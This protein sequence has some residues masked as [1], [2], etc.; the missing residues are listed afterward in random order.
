[1][2][3]VR[4]FASIDNYT[5]TNAS[6]QFDNAKQFAQ[7]CEDK[8]GQSIMPDQAQQILLANGYRLVD[9]AASQGPGSNA[10]AMAYINQNGN[11]LFTATP[12]E[13]DSSFVYGNKDGSLTPEQN[14]LPG[15]DAHTQI[16]VAAGTGVGLV[17]SGAIA[18]VVATAWGLGTAYDFAGDAISHAMG[19]R[20]SLFFGC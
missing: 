7:F 16:G 2:C 6:G 3:R 12:T 11:G 20:W 14:A 5:P 18:P 8:T 4:V 1:M 10:A 17:A 19:L 15:H 9:V 13:Y